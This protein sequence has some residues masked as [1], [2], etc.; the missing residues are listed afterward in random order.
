MQLVS[1]RYTLAAYLALAASCGAAVA[2]VFKRGRGCGGG[3]GGGGGGSR[4]RGVSFSGGG[5]GGGGMARAADAA[6][7]TLWW[8]FLLPLLALSTAP[9]QEPRFLL[10]VALPLVGLYTFNAVDP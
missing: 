1:H 7:A 9:H 10:P 8:T 4:G 3:G 2:S 6:R 5:G